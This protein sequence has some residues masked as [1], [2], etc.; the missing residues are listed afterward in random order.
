[1]SKLNERQLADFIQDEQIFEA[2]RY[3][4]EAVADQATVADILEKAKSCKGLSS[5][6]AAVLL[7]VED[8]DTLER[9]FQVSRGIKEQ[10]YGNRIVLFA[11]LY[12]SNY[13]VN[14]CVYCGYK[15]SN[16]EF[17]RS[18]LSTA[19]IAEE[20]KAL[21]SLGHKRL[22][23]EAGEDPR[24]CSIDYVIDCIRTIYD[25]KHDNGSIRRV[26][27]NIAATTGEDYRRLAE[28]E[29]GTYILFQETYHRPSYRQL[30]SRRPQKRL[31]LAY[32]RH[33]PGHEGGH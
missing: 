28:A 7:H 32:D 15:H 2:L 26:N 13:C 4:E 8:E 5:Q 23:V 21:Q 14:N 18:R 12:I 11:P 30:P 1:M 24:N 27:V 29:I 9:M 3:G 31:R 6:E 10:I 20:V 17:E 16:S 19:E 25:T 22:V 33:G